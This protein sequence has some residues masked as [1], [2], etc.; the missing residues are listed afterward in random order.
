[1]TDS[2]EGL[3]TDKEHEALELTAKLWSQ[4]RDIVGHGPTASKDLNELL[5]HI[6][7]IQHAIMAQAASRAFPELYRTLGGRRSKDEP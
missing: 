1:M 6:H 3:I 5:I 7:S 2:I 4:I